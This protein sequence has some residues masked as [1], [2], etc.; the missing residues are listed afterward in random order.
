MFC[1]ISMH[2]EAEFH[3]L[4]LS[5]KRR[6]PKLYCNPRL[7]QLCASERPV[8]KEKYKGI[9]DLLPD[10]PAIHRE[11]FRAL[12]MSKTENF[13]IEADNNS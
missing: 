11:Y 12:K 1:R 7:P 10:M 3:V 2:P 4:N 5:P 6:K 9:M 8:T 13:V